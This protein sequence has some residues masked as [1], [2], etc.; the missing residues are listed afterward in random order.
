MKAA[1]FSTHSTWLTHLETELEIA[2]NLLNQGYSVD[3][4]NCDNT[5]FDACENILSRSLLDKTKYDEI[6]DL[7]CSC[8]IKRQVR[9]GGLLNEKISKFPIIDNFQKKKKYI[10]DDLYFE[11]HEKFKTLIYD[12]NFDIGWSLL[13]SFISFTR[14]PFLDLSLYKEQ[15]NNLY[16]DSIRVYE[17]AKKAINLNKYDKIYIFNGRFSYTR[18]LYK[19]GKKIGV[20]TFIHERGSVID[21]YEIYENTTPHD[22]TNYF[23]RVNNYWDKAN[24]FTRFFEGKKFFKDKVN[25]FSGSWKSFTNNFEANKLPDQF[26]KFRNNIVLFTSSEDESI[27]VDDTWFIPFFNN[28]LD[29]IE[30]LCKEINSLNDK[31]LR[32]YIRIHP[33]SKEKNENYLN[34]LYSFDKYKNVII[35]PPTSDINSYSL[36]FNADKVITFG[37][38]MTIEAIYWGK[39]VVLLSQ[40]EFNNFKGP[41]TPSKFE[42][43]IDLCFYKK[44]PIPEKI[45]SI[46]I[47]YYLRTFGIKYKYY[48]P[49]D[50]LN[51]YFKG[52]NLSTGEALILPETKIRTKINKLKGRLY[53]LYKFIKKYVS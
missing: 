22:I 46:K 40:G 11:N 44:L 15:I 53:P 33:N 1:L 50:Y 17:S 12:E 43:I 9:G 45:D 26:N 51:G 52:V 10:F 2:Q 16:N 29:G 19:L 48:K 27:A 35:I 7:T 28:Q 39:P 5:S 8:C 3:F 38:T 30:Y 14:D 24:L 37:S 36:L 20:P 32:L 4:Y 6:S 31:N 49:N 18:G 47:G 13:S 25:G 34:K 41:T 21:K 42:D 23:V